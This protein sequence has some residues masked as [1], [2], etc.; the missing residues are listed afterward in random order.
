VLTVGAVVAGTTMAGAQA[1]PELPNR[2]AA[3]LLADVQ[4]AT[5]PGPL[6]ATVQETANLGLPSLPGSS[7]S[8]SAMSLLS[9]THSF[10]IWYADPAHMRVSQPVQLGE[11][12]LRRDG[13]QVWLWNSKN[14]TATHVVLPAVPAG[15]AGDSSA[16]DGQGSPA[17]PPTPQNLARQ[18]LAAV[19]PTTTVSVQQN[20]TVAGQSAYQLAVAPKDSGSLIGRVTIAVDAHRY[21]PLRVQVFARGSSSPAFELGFTSLS[22]GEPAASNFAFTPPADAKVKTIQVPAKF[23]PG[24]AIGRHHH[25][26]HGLS[27]LAGGRHVPGHAGAGPVTVLGKGWLS[28]LKVSA[29]SPSDGSTTTTTTST[30]GSG[31]Y[32]STL[33]ITAGSPS[34]GPG[35]DSRLAAQARAIARTLMREATPVSGSWGSGRLLRTSLVSVLITSKGTVYVGAVEPSVLY[36]D[37]A[38]SK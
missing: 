21:L 11:S 34:S 9:G 2:T 20:V 15:S 32:S 33:T 27:P 18:I 38:A 4:Q 6:T 14:Q 13:R 10:N 37:A 24:K 28:V 1:S 22:F 35:H 3:Q 8:S 26:M 19:G 7:N 36:A 31:A 23:R 29:N 16:G 17:P 5:G 25:G 12:D 30:S